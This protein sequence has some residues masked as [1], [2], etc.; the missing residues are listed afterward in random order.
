MDAVVQS[1]AAEA[2]RSS[3]AAEELASRSESLILM[4]RQLEIVV[5][6]GSK[7]TGDGAQGAKELPA[8]A[9]GPEAALPAG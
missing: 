5:S 8:R 2:D 1:N 9:G 6:G 3:S 4:V 7:S